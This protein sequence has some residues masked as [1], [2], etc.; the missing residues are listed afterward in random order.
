VPRW[1]TRRVGRT[2]PS[3]PP[4]RL[5]LARLRRP[6][7]IQRQPP[8]QD[9][10]VRRRGRVVLPAVGGP[11]GAVEGGVGVGVPTRA[12]R[13]LL[14]GGQGRGKVSKQVVGGVAGIVANAEP[15]S[16]PQETGIVGEG[17]APSS[18]RLPTATIAA[19]AR[20]SGRG[21]RFLVL[22]CGSRFTNRFWFDSGSRFRGRGGRKS[23][24]FYRYRAAGLP[25]RPAP[26]G[27]LRGMS[28]RGVIGPRSDPSFLPPLSPKMDR[29]GSKRHISEKLSSTYGMMG[30]QVIGL[31]WRKLAD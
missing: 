9:I 11:D 12:A 24:R 31:D 22:G 25:G 30:R 10:L 7:P 20:G 3:P 28:P 6:L 2:C 23:D 19:L 13:R 27:A 26:D 18:A 4:G 16:H 21:A 14:N 1:L 17:N 8:P 15:Y 29:G 5:R